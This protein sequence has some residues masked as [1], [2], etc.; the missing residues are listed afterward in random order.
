MGAR[1]VAIEDQ[2]LLE[3][4]AKRV[5]DPVARLRYLRRATS[6][7]KRRHRR[8]RVAQSLLFLVASGYVPC[9]VSD[10]S[11][12]GYPRSRV[13]IVEQP[14]PEVWQVEE[15]KDYQVFSNGLRVENRFAVATRPRT[16]SAGIVYHTTESLQVPLEPAENRLLKRVG[17]S[18]VEFVHRK[19]AYHFVIDRFG[20]VYRVVAESDVANHAG[21]SVWAFGKQT[22]VNLN[23]SFLG[24]AFE[25]QS[26]VG[27]DAVA[28]SVAQVH[29]ARIL[30]DMLRSRYRIRAQNCVTHAQ[31]SVNPANMRAGYHTDWARNF[32]F[33]QVG[34]PDNYHAPLASVYR[35][36]F[37]CDTSFRERAG[38]PLEDGIALAE[39]ILHD[40]ALTEGL[41]VPSYRQAL[42]KR[43]RQITAALH[44][45][46]AQ[47][48]DVE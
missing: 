40:T 32:P 38:K 24:V 26:P 37:V 6:A 35:F 28:I 7:A 45:G 12:L 1:N 2:T 5:A 34:L 3:W 9:I 47:K 15:A 18:L 17:E 14:A 19:H 22:Y 11:T 25:A 44:N 13:P 8:R 29:A 48:G 21:N 43:Y 27:G 16:E 10:A 41:P 36:G 31:V 42:Q 39:G 23:E 33:A 46:R 4:R 30:T 20:R